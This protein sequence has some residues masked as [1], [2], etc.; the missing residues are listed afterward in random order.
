MALQPEQTIPQV[1][2]VLARLLQ[3][4]AAGGDLHPR[5]ESLNDDRMFAIAVNGW[6]FIAGFQPTASAGPLSEAIDS[7]SRYTRGRSK[8]L[9]LVAVP[10]MGELGKRLCKQATVSW[11][12][13]SG[14][15]SIRGPGLLIQI[16][17]R[18]NRFVRRGRPANIFA[19]K[20][21]RITR[22][23]LRYPCRF[24]S[25]A[26][27]ARETG[28]SDGYVSKIARR[29]MHEQ[30]LTADDSAAVRPRDPDL[31]LD[32]WREAYDF[33][34]HRII[35]GHVPARSGEELLQRVAEHFSG[36]A[37]RWAATGLPAAWLYTHFAM[38][39]LVTC[40]ISVLPTHAL[41]DSLQFVEGTE[42]A[43]LWLVVPD[44]EG[45]FNG[46]QI[47]DGICCVS[48]LQAYLD[49]KAQPE[50]ARDA[51]SVLR[52]THLTWTADDD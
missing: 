37:F 25:Q 4:A 36:A 8:T 9:P 27:L 50:R 49:L 39:R 35:K 12:D 18:P 5:I 32:A 3:D 48:P 42:G 1:A 52:C 45:I 19:P 46:A 31:L 22:Q 38:Y 2:E 13:L 14:N 10:Y 29:L 28:L 44:D 23:L 43:N 6:R 24:Q 33:Q 20:S 7:V 11:I 34:H 51:A 47:V 16:E 17:G 15:A 26:E 41:L 21:S 40:Y 30:Y